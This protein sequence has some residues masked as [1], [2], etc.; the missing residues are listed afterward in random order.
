MSNL[1]RRPEVPPSPQ[2]RL[3]SKRWWNGLLRLDASLRWHD[4]DV[5][6]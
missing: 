2:R 4:E 3:G 6:A 5:A 1:C